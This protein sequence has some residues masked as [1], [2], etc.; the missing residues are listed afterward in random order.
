GKTQSAVILSEAKNLSLIVFLYLNRREILRFAQNDK[1][2][3][4]FRSLFS[5]SL[6]FLSSAN[7]KPDRLKPVPL[8][9]RIESL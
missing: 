5:L 3:H 4:F 8:V 2:R 7:F 9:L 6:F 1:T